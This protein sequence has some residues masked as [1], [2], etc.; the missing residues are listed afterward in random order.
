MC[1]SWREANRRTLTVSFA[2]VAGMLVTSDFRFPLLLR[3]IGGSRPTLSYSP[4]PFFSVSFPSPSFPFPS[5]P[6]P[7]L[8]LPLRS[9]S[10]PF[11]S[12]TPPPRSISPL[13]GYA[14][15]QM[16]D[17]SLHRPPHLLFAR[18]ANPYLHLPP[19]PSCNSRS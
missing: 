14:N 8:L 4:Y 12:R 3:A 19:S 13:T 16:A 5:S 1:T 17:E 10:L 2:C 18:D 15:C 7:F 9:P 11:L 6:F